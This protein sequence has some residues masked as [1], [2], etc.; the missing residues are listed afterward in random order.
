MTEPV[1]F[2]GAASFRA[3]LEANHATAAELSVRFRKKAT[4]APSITWPEARDE[5]DGAA[6]SL[7]QGDGAP[8]ICFAGLG[9]AVEL[10]L[11]KSG[12]IAYR[13]GAAL[14][15]LNAFLLIWISLAVGIIDDEGDPANLL[16]AA[17]LLV[18]LVG[19][20]LSRF[21]AKGMALAMA[22]AG[23]TQLL[24][25]IVIFIANLGSPLDLVL[26]V[27]FSAPWALSAGLFWRAA[28]AEAARA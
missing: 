12:H 13:L 1:F 22:A 7:G 3:W 9:L 26:T 17:V 24:A 27:A 14:A 25:T 5:D 19:A 15:A 11:R 2:P 16:F 28:E 4:G 6:L 18:A 8:I 23:G 10:A 21:R 20:M